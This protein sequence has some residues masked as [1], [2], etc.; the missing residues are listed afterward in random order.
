MNWESMYDL[1]LQIFTSGQWHDAMVLNFDTPEKGF[2]SRCSF[3]YETAYL[4][5]NI[6]GIGSPFSRA[7]SALFPLDWEGRRSNTHI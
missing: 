1:T 7:V 5:E 6:N 2:E 4:V 3:G